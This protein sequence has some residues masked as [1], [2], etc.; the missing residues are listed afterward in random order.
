MDENESDF[1]IH[2]VVGRRPENLSLLRQLE[3][4]NAFV[5]RN[6]K[7]ILQSPDFYPVRKV[8]G[9]SRSSQQ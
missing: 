6:A 8:V 5:Y 4:L 7:D 9:R 2:K 1:P 3:T